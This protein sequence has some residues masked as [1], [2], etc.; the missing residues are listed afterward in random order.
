MVKVSEGEK[1][2]KDDKDIGHESSPIPDRNP[3][4]FATQEAA[5]RGAEMGTMEPKFDKNEAR[6]SYAGA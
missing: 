1:V 4:V 3:I 6:A 2:S 5:N